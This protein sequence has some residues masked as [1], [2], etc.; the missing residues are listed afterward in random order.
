[1]RLAS[2]REKFK[3]IAKGFLVAIGN[4]ANNFK[5]LGVVGFFYPFSEILVLK[6]RMAFMGR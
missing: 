2:C 3:I 1:M 4:I 5:I 6:L